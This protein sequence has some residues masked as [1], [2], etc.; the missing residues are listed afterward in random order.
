MRCHPLRLVTSF[1]A[2][3]ALLPA[4]RS[5]PAATVGKGLTLPPAL[6]RVVSGEYRELDD[7]RRQLETELLAL[8][9][10][11]KNERGQRTG[12]K[13]FGYNDALVGEH[14]VEIDLGGLHRIDAICLVP[15]DAPAPDGTNTSALGFPQRFRVLVDDG[16]GVRTVVADRA[17]QDFPNPGDLPVLLPVPPE[18]TARRVR[19]TMSKPWMRGIYR[20]Y[21]LSE[22]MVLQGNRNL[23]TGLAGVKVRTSGSLESAPTWSRQNL[24]DGQSIV[25][26]PIRVV[27][28]PLKHGWES[29]HF[30]DA[31]TQVWVQVDLGRAQP[32]DEVRLLPAKLTEFS[33]T[34]G[35]GFPRRFRV[36]ASDEAEFTTSRALADWTN[37]PFGESGFSPLTIPADRTPARYVRVTAHEL[38]QRNQDIYT[39]ALAELQVYQGDRNIAAGTPVTAHS[40]SPGNNANFSAAALTDGLRGPLFLT[41]WPEWLGGL[42]RRREVLQEDAGIR[43]RLAAL[44]PGLVDVAAW[45]LAAVLALVMLAA[46]ALWYIVRRQQARAMAALQRR[47]AGDL[48]DEIG[49]NLASIAMLAELGQRQHTDQADTDIDEIGRLAGESAAAMRDIVWLTQPGPHD[50]QQ[51]GER[52]RLAAQR[53][54]KGMEW[55]FEI[56]GLD[57]APSLDV[58]RHLLLALKEMLSNVLR[59]AAAHCVEVRLAVREPRFTLEVRDDGR[60]FAPDRQGDGHGFTSLRHRATLVGGE[61]SLASQPGGGTRVALSGLLRP[62]DG[63]PVSPT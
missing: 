16:S 26:A 50:A 15:V 25:G 35:Y 28:K 17:E 51:L 57:A 30:A 55:K 38:W 62:P 37:R 56:D 18:T 46:A 1:A 39:F 63:P 6:A 48:H 27:G 8:P 10:P 49:S 31:A 47:I 60:G 42:S 21:A 24:I 36:E 14:W 52:L 9:A 45:A 7:R 2:V 22:I 23:A 34:H 43:L 12:W 11:S 40:V 59:H 44:Q 58:Q 19:V 3:L 61:L 32:F 54:L 20:A 33:I 13:H 29:E 41:E 4:L 5:Q 53:Q